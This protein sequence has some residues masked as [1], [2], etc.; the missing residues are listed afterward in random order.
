MRLYEFEGAELFRREGIPVPDYALATSPQE[1]REK[2][3]IEAGRTLGEVAELE[4]WEQEGGPPLEGFKPHGAE[5][6]E[7]DEEDDE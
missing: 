3:E 2:A 4:R 7:T 5:D 6:D 1:A